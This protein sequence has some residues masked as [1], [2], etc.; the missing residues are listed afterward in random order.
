M[1]TLEQSFFLSILS[2]HINRRKTIVPSEL[3]DWEKILYYAQI[4]QVEGIVFFQCK[5]FLPSEIKKNLEDMYGSSLLV[6]ANHEHY[7]KRIKNSLSTNNIECFIVKGIPVASYYPLPPLRKMSDTDLVVHSEDRKRV[8]DILLELGYKNE[9]CFEG[10]EWIYYKD[11]YLLELHDS[12]IYSEAINLKAHEE[13]FKNFWDYVHNGVLDWNYHFLYLI[14]HL[15]K[16]L[17]N[18]GVGFRQFMD[19]AAVAKNNKEL[20]W[21]WI[22]EQL[23]KLDMIEFSQ[24]VFAF[25]DAWFG[26]SSPIHKKELDESFYEIATEQVF[27]NGVFGFNNDEN[28]GNSVVNNARKSKNAKIFMFTTAVRKVF[29]KY[30]SLINS[31]KYSFLI[32]KKWLLPYAWIYRIVKGANKTDYSKNVSIV[33]SS[34]VSKETI[35]KREDY[36]KQWGLIN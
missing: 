15:R 33:T 13:Y 27:N 19:I 11:R 2:D 34:F 21:G 25:N 8:H 22:K 16:H 23:I 31:P 18:F 32:G 14:L 7:L 30:S 36:L 3:I 9:S 28:K 26:V 29:P 12:L 24:I 5:S 17:M 10:R 6:F 1:L 20:D 35:D 4:Q